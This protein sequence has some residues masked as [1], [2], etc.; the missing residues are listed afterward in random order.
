MS[1]LVA[2]MPAVIIATLCVVWIL[3]LIAIP[4]LFSRGM[5]WGYYWAF[6]FD[7]LLR[8]LPFLLGPPLLLVLMW[9]RAR[10]RSRG[11]GAV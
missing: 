5:G 4:V 11:E 1:H 6:S 8:S 2:R 9:R 7:E 10:S 3:A